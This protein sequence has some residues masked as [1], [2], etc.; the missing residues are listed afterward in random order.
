M[1][2]PKLYTLKDGKLSEVDTSLKRVCE[3]AKSRLDDPKILELIYIDNDD[4]PEPLRNI[5]KDFI[6]G[7]LSKTDV[8]QKLDQ[9]SE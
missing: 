6:A 9:L 5:L 3:I 1:P 2:I 8:L 7:K 4:A